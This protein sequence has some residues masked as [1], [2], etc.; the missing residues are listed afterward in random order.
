LSAS[1]LQSA[2][3]YQAAVSLQQATPTPLSGADDWEGGSSASG[4]RGATQSCGKT[5]HCRTYWRSRWSAPVIRSL[6]P[7]EAVFWWHRRSLPVHAWTRS[8]WIDQRHSVFRV[9]LDP[10]MFKVETLLAAVRAVNWSRRDWKAHL[11]DPGRD[12]LAT[13]LALHTILS[14]HEGC[15]GLSKPIFSNRDRYTI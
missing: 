13:R 7:A 4:Q 8:G 3:N 14:G 5:R 15:F 6:E 1:P 9:K 12:R 2:R 10:V 11:G